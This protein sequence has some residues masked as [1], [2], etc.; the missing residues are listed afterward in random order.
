[1]NRRLA[2]LVVLLTVLAVVVPPPPAL[3][4][5]APGA[6]L[7]IVRGAANVVHPD[8]SIDAPASSGDALSVGDQIWTLDQTQALVTFF[9]GTEIEM[10][11]GASIV[12]RDMTVVGGQIS[13]TVE[14]VIGTTTH[15]VQALLNPGSSYKVQS[16]SSVALVRGTVFTHT[17]EANGDVNVNLQECGQKPGQPP[18]NACLEFPTPGRFMQVGEDCTLSTRNNVNRWG[19]PTGERVPIVAR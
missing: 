7:T 9:D 13:I 11:A 14:S 1:M 4:Q 3:S 15:R 17:A 6:T 19:E 16:G 12:L 18:T 2:T 5:T 10:G 8:G